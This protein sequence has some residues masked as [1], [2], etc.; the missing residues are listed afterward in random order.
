MTKSTRRAILAGAASIPVLSLP[1]IAAGPDPVFSAIE[2]ARATYDAC[3]AVLRAN[4][5]DW[6]AEICRR[7]DNA[8]NAAHIAAFKTV[9]TTRAGA[10][11]LI[12]YAFECLERDGPDAIGEYNEPNANGEMEPA[13]NDAENLLESL[14]AFLQG[15]A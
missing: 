2:H 11:A 5:D 13:G 3:D 14:A 15:H 7:A 9:P 12:A 1:A 6:D 8:W 4:G 10:L